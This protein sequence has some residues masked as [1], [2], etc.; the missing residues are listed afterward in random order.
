MTYSV[1]VSVG[2]AAEANHLLWLLERST[3]VTPDAYVRPC[4]C[5][6][7]VLLRHRTSTPSHPTYHTV[8]VR[9]GWAFG[10]G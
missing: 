7:S 4:S 10:Q 6:V 3:D 9:R 8:L 2:L 1:T 5:C